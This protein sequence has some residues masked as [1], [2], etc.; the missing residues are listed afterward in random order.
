MRDIK[1][2]RTGQEMK[3]NGMCFVPRS[4]VLQRIDAASASK[5]KCKNSGKA[6]ATMEGRQS[7]RVEKGTGGR[8][9]GVGGGGGGAGTVG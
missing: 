7:E 3:T 4:L 1:R 2:K 9:R 6:E 8:G 5:K